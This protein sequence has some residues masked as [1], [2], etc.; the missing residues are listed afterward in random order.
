MG[1]VQF[2][3]L[4]L[5]VVLLCAFALWVLAQLAPS[6]P[7]II[8]ACVW[9]LAAVIIVLMLLQAFGLTGHDVAIPRLR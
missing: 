2:L 9:V 7:P 8:D 1:L 6:H 5:A 4:V 3:F